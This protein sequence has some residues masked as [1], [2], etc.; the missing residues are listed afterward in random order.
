MTQEYDKTNIFA[1]ILRGELETN[2]I[3]ENEHVLAF[4]D[5]NPCAPTHILVITK[6][7]YINF[8]D[9]ISKASKNQIADYYSSLAYIAEQLDISDYRI[10]S[11]CGTES[12]QSVFHFH[13]HII[14]GKS[15]GGLIGE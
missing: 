13:T 7:N 5:I 3:F 9:F 6:E 4:S 2:K 1:K 12:G 8:S 10:I 14:S 15:L 11:N